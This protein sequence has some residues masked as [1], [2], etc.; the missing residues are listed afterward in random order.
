MNWISVKDHMPTENIEDCLVTI[1]CFGVSKYMKIVSYAKDLSEVDEWDF[2]TEEYKGV[3][4]FYDYDSECG[5]YE[6]SNVLAWL[7]VK[8]YEGE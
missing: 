2:P 1:D 4:G 5:Y 3:G 6:V 7:E 8:F